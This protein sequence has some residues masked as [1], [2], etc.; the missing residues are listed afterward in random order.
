VQAK[1]AA[2]G[3][4]RK[5]NQTNIAT[6]RNRSRKCRSLIGPVGEASLGSKGL[7][8]TTTVP[9]VPLTNPGIISIPV[10]FIAGRLGSFLGK[11]DRRA[12]E[13]FDQLRLRAL[14]G[15]GAEE[16]ATGH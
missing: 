6:R 12:D 5:V 10:G 14:T 8:L 3:G 1:R 2:N 13:L 11:R 7:I 4:G 15:F 16:S 9:L